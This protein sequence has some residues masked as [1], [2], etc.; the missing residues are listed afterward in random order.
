MTRGSLQLS[1]QLQ[2]VL[3]KVQIQLI[4]RKKSDFRLSMLPEFLRRD[5]KVR[6]HRKIWTYSGMLG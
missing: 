2:V 5:P 4:L 6:L 1:I 3:N